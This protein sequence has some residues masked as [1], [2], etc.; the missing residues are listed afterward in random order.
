MLLMYAKIAYMKLMYSKLMWIKAADCTINGREF[1][2]E[3]FL[4]VQLQALCMDKNLSLSLVF[5]TSSSKSLSNTER[6]ETHD[7]LL[8]NDLFGS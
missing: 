3:L 7:V 5:I 6:V 8:N 4:F 2:T 1:L